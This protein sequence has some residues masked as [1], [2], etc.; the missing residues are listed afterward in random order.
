MTSTAGNRAS[1]TAFMQ[2]LRRDHAGLSRMLRAIDGLADRLPDEPETVQ[3]VLIEAF[4]YLLGYQHG[5]HH[6]REDRLF[7]R[8]RDRRPE[9][10]ETLEQLADEHETGEHE[11]G[12]LADDLASATPEALRGRLGRGQAARIRD[13]VR[14]A[15]L[16]MRSE[17][18]V[19]Y[20]R[21]EDVL[22]ENDW[23]SIVAD[24][25][26]QDPLADLESLADEYPALAAHFDIRARKTGPV[27]VARTAPGPL[28]GHVL[29]LTD[30]YGG[31]L[32]EGFDLTRRNARRL[33]AVRGPIGLVRAF[34]EITTDNLRFAGQ[35]IS[36]PSRWAVD[37]G[38]DLL[39]ARIKP[40][41]DG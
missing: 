12:E 40:D 39:A 2:A 36:R 31:L 24:D 17:E 8:I 34:G 35:C 25:G 23:A 37:T 41:R 7:E 27:D 33:M 14:H 26:L 32:H 13:Y 22:N 10:A 38:T 16:H 5:Y 29:S 19:F 9:L 20:A 3:P 28:H 11:T 15:R 21:A 1:A 4:D 18:A 30:L 6:P